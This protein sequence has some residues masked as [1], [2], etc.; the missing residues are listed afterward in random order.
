VSR[1]RTI[2]F[3]FDGTIANTLPLIYRVFNTV[4]EPRIGRRLPDAEIRSHFGP[5]DQ[6]ILGRYVGEVEQAAAFAEYVERYRAHHHE[7]VHLYDGIH[8][9][10]VAAR[11]DGV[12][13]GVMT[14]KSRVT[15]KISF[16]ALGIDDL[17]DVLVAG[18]DV[19]MP[20]PHPEGVLRVLAELG[21]TTGE[22]GAMVGD[23]A[24][25]VYAG[26][27]AGLTTV[28]VTWGVPEHDDLRAAGPDVICDST[29]ELAAALDLRL[30]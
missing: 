15:A 26:R 28:G 14:G 30:A 3:D 5:P 17:I 23:S 12:R 4:L 25:D 10:L 6:T 19:A 9:L 21:H 7:H 11:Q 13:I 16:H 20:K 27:D 18:D 29:A 2:V 22:P 1:F 8:D 24:A